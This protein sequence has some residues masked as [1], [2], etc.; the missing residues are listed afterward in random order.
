MREASR[1]HGFVNLSDWLR[2][3]VIASGE[4]KLGEPFPL[5]EARNPPHRKPNKR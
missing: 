3:L 1:A 2:H 5:P 4:A